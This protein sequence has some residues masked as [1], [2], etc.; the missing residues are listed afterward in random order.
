MGGYA[1]WQRDLANEKEQFA[2]RLL[3]A[4]TMN[5]AAAELSELNFTRARDLLNLYLPGSNTKNY[6]GLRN[7]YW[8]YLWR[9][10]DQELATL[11]GHEHFVTCLSFSP[12]G[13]TLASGGGDSTVKLWDVG[14]RQELVTLKGHDEYVLSVAFSPDGKTLA[15]GSADKKVKLWD[16]GTRQELAT[17][18][19]GHGQPISEV[20][21]S[22]DGK[23]LAT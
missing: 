4:V 3:Y 12:D 6:S 16:V 7:F 8:Y 11:K 9:Q 22:P 20:A 18:I 10:S 14:S 15:T 17:L 5:L 13:K 23:T 19:T 21:F 2:D 1:L